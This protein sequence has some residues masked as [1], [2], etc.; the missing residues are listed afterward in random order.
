MADGIMV[1]TPTGGGVWQNSDVL[2]SLIETARR[3]WVIW[4]FKPANKIKLTVEDSEFVHWAL[5]VDDG[6]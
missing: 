4:S 2:L 3:S 5:G 1:N 6:G